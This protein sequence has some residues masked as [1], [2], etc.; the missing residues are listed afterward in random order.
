[1]NMYFILSL[2]MV[3][4]YYKLRYNPIQK[5]QKQYIIIIT[6]LLIILS[7]LR[8]EAV[9]N[10]TYASMLNFERILQTNWSEILSG[11]WDRYIDPSNSNGKDPAEGVALKLI[12]YI[13]SNSRIFLFI[14]AS[15]SLSSLGYFVYKTSCSLRTTLL[16]YVFY[17]NFFYAYVPNSAF[18]QPMAIAILLVAYL[19]L[20]NGKYLKFCILLFI[21]SFFHKSVLVA[22]TMLPLYYLTK[23]RGIK[24]FYLCFLV[25]FVIML[26]FYQSVGKFLSVGS[27]VYSG[28][29]KATFYLSST[30]KPVMVI[31]LYFIFYIYGLMNI[32]RDLHINE[33][34]LQYFGLA[35]S[36]AFLPLIWIDP[37]A[38]RLIAYF[39]IF[40]P[41]LFGR[42]YKEIPNQKFFYQTILI[43]LM[44]KLLISTNEYAFMWEN[45]ALHNRYSYVIQYETKVINYT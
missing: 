25:V 23:E 41:L 11:F 40:I 33:N 45:K 29:S 2:I 42:Y 28:Y 43:V 35:L 27:S 22:G 14:S 13:T 1:M 36:I 10:D 12:S 34:R 32:N 5:S 37:S 18:R 3:V 39:G 19:A 7:S 8:H 31:F 17:V 24:G 20:A 44:L 30:N 4:L 6:V 38:L 15:L 9:G 16:V 26:F 21:A